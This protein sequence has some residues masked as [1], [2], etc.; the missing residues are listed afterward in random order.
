MTKSS[1]ETPIVVIA[2]RRP[3]LLI[4]TLNAIEVVRPKKVFFVQDWYDDHT[5]N[6]AKEC[7]DV[8]SIL[9]SI[10]WPCDITY[11]KS[12][13]NMGLK[14]RVES[15]LNEVFIQVDR[16]IVL[17]D[18]VQIGTSGLNFM[19]TMLSEYVNDEF[20]WHVNAVNLVQAFKLQPNQ[21]RFSQYAHSWGWA[22]WAN[23]WSKYDGNLESW[24]EF[25][26]SDGFR[27]RFTHRSE[28]K[29]W[30]TIFDDVHSGRNTSSWAYPWLAT[31]WQHNARAI[32][33]NVNYVLNNGFDA[34][35]THTKTG[36]SMSIDS[37]S[38]IEIDSR[39]LLAPESQHLNLDADRD[40]FL[41][42]Y[43]GRLRT[44]KNS[45]IG[46]WLNQI[47]M[48]AMSLRNSI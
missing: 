46:K 7:N 44:M 3:D 2:F 6:F 36:L 26:V 8:S 27:R 20:V 40:E 21:Y 9:H 15:G 16:A 25:S 48:K 43:G 1:Y 33:P 45:K 10:K 30:K 35:A 47:R 29:Y 28:M 23:R 34:R 24:P 37:E 17:E 4:Q 14:Y 39:N 32:S 11:I 22:T 13:H 38:D 18:D 5:S 41:Y 12:D 19:Q 31:M 42:H